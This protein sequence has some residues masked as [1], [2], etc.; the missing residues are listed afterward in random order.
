[1][2]EGWRDSCTSEYIQILIRVIH[3]TKRNN[4]AASLG[5][6]GG[7]GATL[8]LGVV[9]PG[10]GMFCSYRRFNYGESPVGGGQTKETH[11]LHS[12]CLWPLKH[13][14]ELNSLNVSIPSLAGTL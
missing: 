10:P 7:G 12:G 4:M 11:M 6:W 2:C 14:L 1:M 13:M 8:S 9:L 3:V 5:G